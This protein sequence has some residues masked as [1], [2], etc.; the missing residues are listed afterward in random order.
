[1]PYGCHIASATTGAPAWRGE[2]AG[3]F[4]GNGSREVN[5]A[6]IDH[7][8]HRLD[9]LRHLDDELGSRDL[10]ALARNELGLIV[11]LLR[12]GRYTEHTGRRL[13]SL[14]AEVG[15]QIAWSEFDQGHHAAAARS[16]EMSLRA[17]ATAEDPVTG[18]YALSFMA[19]QC[20]STGQ[21]QQA[22][23]LLD[24]A[25]TEVRTL[26]TPRMTA[27]LAARSARAL[28][29]TGDSKGCAHHLHLA[30]TALEKGPSPDDP[31]TLYWVTHGEIEMIA[32]SSALELGNP[33]QAIR[34]FN[35]AVAADYRGDDRYPRTHAIYLAR[36]AEAHL[37]LH[38]LDAAI[39][40]ATHAMRCLG[41]VDSAR[42]TSTLDGL[43]T[44]LADH[45]AVPLV[46][47]FLDATR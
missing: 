46:H 45:A 41:G 1:M 32:G 20:Y 30:E 11:P 2:K 47:D 40:T 15:R 22:V 17:S 26:G 7:I 13:Y 31:P 9:H 42:S 21:P 24:T 16:F 38:D 43:R 36:A 23:S 10:A 37:A 27:M 25:Q 4:T 33:A 6:L 34:H 8:D 19:V 18:A 14:A 12:H 3:D 39:D 28:S 5:P 44:K 29:K 35:A